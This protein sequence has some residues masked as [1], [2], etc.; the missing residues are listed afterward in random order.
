VPTGPTEPV[1][2]RRASILPF[3]TTILTVVTVFL[4]FV[5][6]AQRWFIYFP[7]REPPPPHLVGLP[8]GEAVAFETE[9][10]LRLEG[11]FVRPTAPPTG[12]T[13][14]MFNGNGGHRGYRAP[15]AAALAARG[16]ACFLFDYRG[17]GGNPGLPSERGLTRDARAARSAVTSRDDVDPALLVYYGESLGAAVAV[18]LAV[19][20]PPHALILRSPFTSLTDIGQLHYPF[21][22]VRW[23]L[24]DRFVLLDRLASIQSATLVI[25]GTADRIVPVDMSTEVYE[26]ANEP[27]WMATV[28]GADHNDESLAVGQPLVG[29]VTA[30][31]RG[32]HQ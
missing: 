9:D 7:D 30:F 12:Q 8:S 16:L 28:E 21:L 20:H 17:F 27:K 18:R 29:A 15:L 26:A 1:R 3:M 13:V 5:W 10:G 2:H 19:D 31:L 23:L 14:L 11:W 22:P 32:I 4:A 6:F 24:R 25:A